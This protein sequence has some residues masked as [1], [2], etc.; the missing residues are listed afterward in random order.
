MSQSPTFLSDLIK[1]VADPLRGNYQRDEAGNV[2]LPSTVFWRIDCVLAP[3]KGKV[4]AEKAPREKQ[5]VNPG[6][7]LLRIAGE[8]SV[9]TSPLDLKRL[10]GDQDYL[11]PARV[12]EANVEEIWHAYQAR[13]GE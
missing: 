5:T 13:R 1:P 4:L 11:T 9:D 8:K 12:R 6:P 7:S 3:T 10:V 2:I